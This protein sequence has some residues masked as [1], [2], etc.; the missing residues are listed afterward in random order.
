MV[1]FSSL[2]PGGAY[3]TIYSGDCRPTVLWSL[4]LVTAHDAMLIL[5][6]LIYVYHELITTKVP[7]IAP[8]VTGMRLLVKRLFLLADNE[9][10]GIDG[11]IIA[12]Y[13]E[14]A[15][16]DVIGATGQRRQVTAHSPCGKLGWGSSTADI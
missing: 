9:V 2:R 14:C 8:H 7:I 12:G 15:R 3:L 4:N 13:V 16:F 10:A 5:R 6:P 11:P 1:E